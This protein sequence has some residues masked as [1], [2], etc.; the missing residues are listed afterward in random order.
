MEYTEY[1]LKPLFSK[2]KSF[3]GKA[4]VVAACNGNDLCC[5]LR[6][7]D[8]VVLSVYVGSDGAP[9][10]KRLWN[11]YS[12]TTMRHVNELLAQKGFPC[13]KSRVWRAMAVGKFYAPGEVS[14]LEKSLK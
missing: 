4:N 3:Y 1:E 8:T 2:Q 10:V 12:A 14:A 5:T 6:S 7:Y 11:G 13:L 9:Y